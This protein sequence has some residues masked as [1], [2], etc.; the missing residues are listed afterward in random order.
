M[1]GRERERE[2]SQTDAN[3]PRDLPSRMRVLLLF[4]QRRFFTSRKG[5][6]PGIEEGKEEGSFEAAAAA[7]AVECINEEE[8]EEEATKSPIVAK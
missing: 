8:E 2:Q 4:F 1:K 3:V 6:V 7:N 5:V